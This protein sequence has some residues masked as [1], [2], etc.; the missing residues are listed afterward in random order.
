MC[1]Y[2]KFGAINKYEIQVPTTKLTPNVISR[3]KPKK[4]NPSKGRI[5]QSMQKRMKKQKKNK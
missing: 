3:K 1:K 4:D 5:G 2:I